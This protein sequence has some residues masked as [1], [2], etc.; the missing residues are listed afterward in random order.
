M[1]GEVRVPGDK[2]VSHRALIFG[3]LAEGVSEASGLAPGAD[4]RSTRGVLEALGVEFSDAPGGVVRVSGRGLGGLTAPAEALDAGNSGTTTRL[5]A[6]VLAGHSFSSEIAG[7]ESLNRRPMKRVAEPL[8]AMGAKIDLTKTGTAPMTIRGGD[9]RGL[10]YEMPVASAQVKSAILLAGLHAAGTTIVV[11]KSPT[12]DHTERMLALFGAPPKLHGGAVEIEGGARLRAARVEVPGDPSSAAFWVVAAAARE[13]GE[14][15]VRGV[16]SNS[17]RGGYLRVLER[18]GASVRRE[19]APARGGE[20]CEDLIARGGRLRGVEVA[21]DEIPSLVDEVPILALA[22][23]VAEGESRFRGLDELRHKESDRL[24]AI[25]ELLGRFGAVARV[26]GDDL[27][28]AGGARLRGARIDPR[29]DHRLAMTAYVAGFLAEGE[30]RV[31]DAECASISYPSFYDDFD[32][33]RSA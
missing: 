33:R 13:G 32:A 17:S 16:L 7:D 2:S 21:A 31:R 25:A 12:R 1:R 8:R 23:A 22:A 15:V 19:P 11:E 24:A 14:I 3:A 5:M 10:A 28:V 18:M 27:I 20:E 26:S 9:L 30:T 6:G 29:A 4:V